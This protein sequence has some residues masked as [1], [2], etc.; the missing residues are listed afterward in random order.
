MF[1]ECLGCLKYRVE[2]RIANKALMVPPQ[3]WERVP[4]MTVG[5]HF[6]RSQASAASKLCFQW[7]S[8][9][10]LSR[11]TYM[12][13]PIERTSATLPIRLNT[14]SPKKL[15][16]VDYAVRA[17]EGSHPPLGECGRESHAVMKT[18]PGRAL[19]VSPRRVQPGGA[20]VKH[21]AVD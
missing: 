20:C 4:T 11:P 17:K 14:N 15:A 9:R 6:G 18:G 8:V 2:N 21:T 16:K 12:R 10:R 5:V 19:D 7:L 13:K 1:D 3:T